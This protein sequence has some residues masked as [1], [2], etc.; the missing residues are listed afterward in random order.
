MNN[1]TYL[2]GA[3]AS[4]NACPILNEMGDKMMEL[5]KILGYNFDFTENPNPRFSN[6]TEEIAWTIGY[7]G[8]LAKEFNTIDTYAKKLYLLES[9]GEELSR[10]KSA[11]SLFFTFWSNTNNENWRLLKNSNGKARIQDL[12]PRYINLLAT[13]LERGE[14]NPALSKNVKF[15]TWNYD[16]QLEEAYRKFTRIE[17]NDFR[18]IDKFFPFIPTSNNMDRIVSCHLNG[19]HG[20]YGFEDGYDLFQRIEKRD[21]HYLVNTIAEIL[22][23]RI[24]KLNPFAPFV[25]YAWEE[26]S[27]ITKI[28]R[29]KAMK[30]FSATN[31]L[32]VI[33]YSFPPF[34]YKVDKQLLFLA[35]NS[36]KRLIIQDPAV[37]ESFISETFEID[38][39]KISVIRD[40][41][42]FVIPNFSLNSRFPIL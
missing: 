29:Q 14:Q 12:D 19:F 9:K 23:D 31:I 36:L 20:F 16:L 24:W 10:L 8:Y 33:G 28:A 4:Y 40:T 5:S 15:V 6:I 35:K 11:I 21:L 7:F 30:I 2:F 25:N 13:Y 39:N 17:K 34:N 26:E 42:Q 32:V 18:T 37:D 3:G 27:K 1:I 41:K 38:I 22:D